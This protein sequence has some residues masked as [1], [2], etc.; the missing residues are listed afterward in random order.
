MVSNWWEIE[1]LTDFVSD[2]SEQSFFKVTVDQSGH[3]SPFLGGSG[4]E[5][6]PKDTYSF[7]YPLL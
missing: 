2:L 4:R 1:I 5:G 6:D 3:S 7:H